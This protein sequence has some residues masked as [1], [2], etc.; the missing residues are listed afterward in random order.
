MDKLLIKII[1]KT[2]VY[3]LRQCLANYLTPG[4]LSQQ[5]RYFSCNTNYNLLELGLVTLGILLVIAS[6]TVYE[7]I[8]WR[9]GDLDFKITAVIEPPPSHPFAPTE[10][11]EMTDDSDVPAQSEAD[12]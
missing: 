11:W 3:L 8:A 10:N 6:A 9:N 7:I 4:T 1:I 2:V 12:H 5:H